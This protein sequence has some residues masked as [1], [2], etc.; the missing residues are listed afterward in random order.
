MMKSNKIKHN[1]PNHY[2]HWDASV[3]NTQQSPTNHICILLI[4]FS[5]HVLEGM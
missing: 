4:D 1:K 2:T 3:S 5:L